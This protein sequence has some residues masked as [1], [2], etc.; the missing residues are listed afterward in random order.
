MVGLAALL[1]YDYFLTLEDEVAE[2]H[3]DSDT[4]RNLTTPHRS[5]MHGR[6]RMFLVSKYSHSLWSVLTGD[7]LVFVIFLFVSTPYYR[8]H[9]SLTIAQIRYLPLV[10]QVWL[11]IRKWNW[12]SP[13]YPTHTNIVGRRLQSYI[14]RESHPRY[15]WF[16]STCFW[17]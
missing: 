14:I 7:I 13:C 15:A 10:I 1:I 17:D 5:V 11:L 9:N 8:H 6:R 12:D 4:E 2:F 3:N 16:V